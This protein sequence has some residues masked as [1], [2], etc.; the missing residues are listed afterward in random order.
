MPGTG[1]VLLPYLVLGGPGRPPRP[2]AWPGLL[3]ILAGLTL[4]GWCLWLFASVGRGTPGPW[5]APRRLVASGPYRWV[6]NPIYIGVLLVILGEAW[7]FLSWSLV[8]YALG[9]ALLFHVFVLLYEEP[10]LKR[11]FPDD[12]RSYFQAVNRWLPRPP[13]NPPPR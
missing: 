4:Y 12:Y 5:D 2:V 10:T 3:P 1:A 6:R 7:L 13:R 9:A 11:L 8:V